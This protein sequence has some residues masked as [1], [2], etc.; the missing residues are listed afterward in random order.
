M[1]MTRWGIAAM[2]ALAA[3]AP[4]SIARAYD[5]A[6]THAGLTERAALASDL[7]RVLSHALSRPLG[8]FEPVGLSLAELPTADAQSLEA[9]LAT[10][11]PSGGAAAGPDGVAPALA[12][13]IAG[14]IIAT[15][16]AERGQDFF[17]DPSRGSGLSQSGSVASVGNTLGLLFDAGGG[18]RPLF[19]GTQFNMTG[20]PSTE[21]LRAPENDVGLDAFYATLEA[22]VAGDRPVVRATSLARALMALGG[23]LTILEDAGEPAHVRNDFRRTYLASPGVSPFDR[24]SRFEQYVAETYGRMG[25]P[26]AGTPVHRP[27][28]MAYITA[29]DKQGLADRTQSRFFSDGSLPEDAIVD[30]GATAAE[31][32]ADARGSLPYAYP[33]LP[34][35]ELKVMGRRHYAY[36]KSKR[37]LLAYERVPGRVR[38][39]LDDAVYADTARVL[40]PEIAG[41]GAGLINHLFRA[42]IRVEI[43]GGVAQVT[44]AGAQGAV[45][46]GQI[47]VFAEDGSGARR[48]AATLPP[49]SEPARLAVPAG[50][51]KIAAVLRGEDDA[52]EFVAVGEASVR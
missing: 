46:K 22:A 5:P 11:D 31:V 15:T 10:L 37:R 25:L 3:T 42:E 8:L 20:R 45:R 2:L 43:T 38:F 51:R 36:A 19:T 49:G 47:R 9:R 1:K 24:G 33:Q 39:F 27:T 26:A 30:R 16:P 29:A 21:W 13:I 44:L 6:T 28:V 48:P 17:Y 18:F 12:W 7:H 40:L 14:S 52:G 23:V 4:S 50:T 32:M 41:Y 34:R 35:L